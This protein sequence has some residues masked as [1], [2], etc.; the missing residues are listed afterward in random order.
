MPCEAPQRV[1]CKPG[2]RHTRCKPG[3]GLTLERRSRSPWT[4]QQSIELAPAAGPDP[5]QLP[6]RPHHWQRHPR[7]CVALLEGPA[8]AGACARGRASLQAE[9][10]AASRTHGRRSTPA[11]CQLLSCRHTPAVP[12]LR[13]VWHP[14]MQALVFQ[15]FPLLAPGT[16]AAIAAWE[17]GGER[18][19]SCPNGPRARASSAA[20]PAHVVMCSSL[21]AAPLWCITA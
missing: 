7:P 16:K 9:R 6:G 4:A 17:R 13:F 3:F 21:H 11:C 12:D 20:S 15:N 5:W 18:A 10:A 2:L 19:A 14:P 8:P 1:G